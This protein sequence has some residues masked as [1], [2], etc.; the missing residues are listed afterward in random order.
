MQGYARL[1]KDVVVKPAGF[2][3]DEGI[4]GKNICLNKCVNHE[5][6]TFTELA[7]KKKSSFANASFLIK[8]FVFCNLKKCTVLWTVFGRTLVVSGTEKPLQEVVKELVSEFKT[9]S[10]LEVLRANILHANIFV[11]EKL[12]FIYNLY[13]KY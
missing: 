6:K 3:R 11:E 4:L 8:F 9:W 1:F 10:C 5:I 7:K 2:G 12:A 13:P